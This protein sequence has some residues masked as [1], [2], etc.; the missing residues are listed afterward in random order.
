MGGETGWRV[1]TVRRY[2]PGLDGVRALAV[3]AVLAFHDNRLSGGFLGVSTFFTLSGFLITGLL[4]RER[5]TTGRVALGAFFGRRIRR[6]F[7]A[8]V[9]GVLL[10][11]AVALA[12]HD[13]QTAQS[14]PTDALAALGDVAN[15]RFLASDQSYANLFATPSPLQHYWS[16]AVE[17]QFYLVLAPLIAGLLIVLRGRRRALLV[18]LGGLTALSFAAGWLL[19][20]DGVDR[21]YY[22]TDTRAAEFLV[23][24]LVAVA[25]SCR[26]IGPR[27]SRAFAI[28]GPVALVA[29]VWANAEAR[30]GHRILFRGG[31]LAYA[32]IG[33]VLLVSACQPGPVRA[34]CSTA[35]LRGLGRISYGVYV[36]HWPIF[37]WLTAARTGL[38]PLPLTALRVS[39]TVG[40]A[41]VSFHLLEQPIRE[42]RV[43]VNSRRGLAFVTASAGALGAA[44][45]VGAV[46][47]APAV[48]FEAA[49]S[50]SSVLAASQ[51]ALELPPPTSRP[52]RRTEGTTPAAPRVSRV[53]VVGDSV[54]LTLGRGI[55]RWGAANGVYVLNGGALGCPLLAGVDVRGYWGVSHQP[56]DRCNTRESWPKVLDEFRPDV[57]VVLYGAWDVYDASFDG[58]ATWVS[59]GDPA[60]DA[61]YERQVAETA[62]RLTATGARLL[63]LTPPCF[64]AEP[65]ADDPDAPW[66]DRARV[67]TLGAIDREVARRNGMQVSS[68]VHDLGC[69]VDLESRPD[70][71]HYADAGADAVARELGPQLTRRG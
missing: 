11:A 28:A 63:W 61:F 48:N 55:E 25:L 9:A 36:Y 17:E 65:G 24:A 29:L 16:L 56:A 8:A 2:E 32:C 53:M 51:R 20:A 37:L 44:V 26:S 1:G 50:P 69:P 58:G 30:V 18:A 12:L 23:G 38:G 15:W 42:R 27:A 54:A 33:C 70:G 14:F 21:A 40:L 4:L 67:E 45:L 64:A 13:G 5:Q 35:P 46:A 19:S 68:V 49:A 60:W 47:T 41:I 10:A 59:P 22:G 3:L 7:P 39:F 6:L 31:L 71:V 66:Y 52:T 57:V 34:L 62:T 43:L